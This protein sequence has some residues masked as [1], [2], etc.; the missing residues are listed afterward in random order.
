M[1]F[2]VNMEGGDYGYIVNM[3]GVYYEWGRILRSLL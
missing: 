3:D 2:T 1:G